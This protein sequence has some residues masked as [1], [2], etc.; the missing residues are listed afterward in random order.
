[1]KIKKLFFPHLVEASQIEFLG[2]HSP[3]KSR[4]P[5]IGTLAALTAATWC[6]LPVVYGKD[7][8]GCVMGKGQ[9]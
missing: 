1:M 2:L 9:G 4:V 5:R 6:N 3:G 8:Y 7:G